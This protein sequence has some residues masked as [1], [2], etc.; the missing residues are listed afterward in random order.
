[1][2]PGLSYQFDHSCY[3]IADNITDGYFTI[4]GLVTANSPD[5]NNPDYSDTFTF[6]IPITPE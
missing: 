2:E 5:E 3:I 1:M 4:E 6:Q